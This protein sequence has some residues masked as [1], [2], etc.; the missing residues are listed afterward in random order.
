MDLILIIIV[1]V[2]FAVTTVLGYFYFKPNIALS[3]L[4]RAIEIAYHDDN[5]KL[6]LEEK[7]KLLNP[8]TLDRNILNPFKWTFDSMFPGLKEYEKNGKEPGFTTE[9]DHTKDQL[10]ELL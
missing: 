1:S 7:Y 8:L 6:Y 4:D 2:L 5:R 3:N 10:L 9:R